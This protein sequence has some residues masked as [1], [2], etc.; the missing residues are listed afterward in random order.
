MRWTAAAALVLALALLVSGPRAG[1]D[2]AS[3]AACFLTK[4]NESRVARGYPALVTDAALTTLA[5]G[6]AQ[7]MARIQRAVPIDN[8]TLVSKAPPEAQVLGQNVGVGADCQGLHD[9]FLA[10]PPEQ[11][12]ILDPKFDKIGVG[13]VASGDVIYV[14]EILM[15]SGPPRPGQPKPSVAPQPPPATRAPSPSAH[16]PVSSPSLSAAP[17]TAA[18]ETSP[19]PSVAPSE[20]PAAPV[21]PVAPS[22]SESVSAQG[23]SKSRGVP[24]L[25]AFAL[26]IVGAAALGALV[27]T[28]RSRR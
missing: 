5:N 15:E 9:T 22:P 23:A 26:M 3:D 27:Q 19:P 20:T 12:R 25:V 6:Q 1:A 4:A 28:R 16:S 17:S 11:N 7:E 13:V 18:S 14:S 24:L 21:V 2:P 10:Y 8:A